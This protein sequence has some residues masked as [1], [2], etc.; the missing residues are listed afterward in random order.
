MKAP[1]WR[2]HLCA[3]LTAVILIALPASGGGQAIEEVYTRDKLI[4]KGYKSWTLFLVCSPEWLLPQNKDRLTDLYHQFRAFGRN[5]GAE[6]AAVWFWIRPPRWATDAVIDNVDVERS[7]TYCQRF[8]LPPSGGPYVF[9]TSTYPDAASETISHFT[10]ALNGRL[11]A[12][13]TKVLSAFADELVIQG[14]PKTPADTEV[15]WRSLQAS[16]EA[17]QG[18]LGAFLARVTFSINTP[19]FKVEI[20]G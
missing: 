10:L 4:P 3:L 8:K 2:T 20:K 9:G 16:F 13:I 18:K 11:P 6:H 5:I 1:N 14:V 12:E 17:L 15:F 19:W 7:V